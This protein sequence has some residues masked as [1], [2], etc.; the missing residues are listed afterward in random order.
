MLVP[1]RPEANAADLV[2]AGVPLLY[3]TDSGRSGTAPAVDP[4][5]L[6][7]LANAG[8]GRLGA[9]RAATELSAGAAGMRRRT[10][11]LRVGEPAAQVLLPTSPLVEPGVWRTPSAVFADG[12]LTVSPNAPN[13]R[14]VRPSGASTGPTARPTRRR[15]ARDRRR[16]GEPMTDAVTDTDLPAPDT[17]NASRSHRSRRP[18]A[19]L[20]AG[21]ALAGVLTGLLWHAWSPATVSYLVSGG[22]G[23]PAF[24][25]PEESESQIAGDGRFVLISIGLGMVFGLVAWRL[26][27]LRGPVVLAALAVGGVLSSVLARVVGELLSSGSAARQVN[28][29][30]APQLSLHALPALTIQ[31]FFGVLVYTALVGLSADPDLKDRRPRSEQPLSGDADLNP[32]SH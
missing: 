14:A 15:P 27:G 29:E 28:A 22:D 6:D 19:L 25:I 31:A 13:H 2:A 12:R 26:R 5:V 8:L 3:G 4:R 17:G 18:L 9:L 10:G 7:R 20:M 21:Q 30:F 32:S 11:L 1:A 24:V 16:S 23:K